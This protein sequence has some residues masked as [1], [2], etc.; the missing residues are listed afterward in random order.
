MF[1][2][3][4]NRQSS[5]LNR[6]SFTFLN[7]S[8]QE[9]L[10]RALDFRAMKPAELA[11]H[12]GLSPGAISQWRSG[13]TANPEAGHAQA[14]ADALRVPSRWLILGEGP[15]PTRQPSDKE[16]HHLNDVSA[17]YGD[18]R[19][20]VIEWADVVAFVQGG[21]DVKLN[22]TNNRIACPESHGSGTFAVRVRGESMYH[23]HAR[24]MF[25][26]GDMIFVD[27][28][29]QPEDRFFVVVQPDPEQ[30][31][32]LRQLLVEGERR[33]LKALNPAWPEPMIPFPEGARVIGVVIYRGEKTLP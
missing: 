6:V 4:N 3:L 31:P 17:D 2:M 14:A 23:P 25:N 27:P 5:A 12:I 11:R 21:R 10:Q 26:D 8:F 19:V 32:I 9:R 29:R 18:D 7:M 33:Y 13:D 24:P 1:S 15:D 20:P 28:T 22:N 16:F 30:P